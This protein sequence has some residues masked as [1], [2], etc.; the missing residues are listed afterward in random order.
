[1]NPIHTPPKK[2]IGNDLKRKMLHLD[3]LFLLQA[4]V[5]SNLIGFSWTITLLENKAKS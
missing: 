2:K 1:L 4:I 5:F 3:L